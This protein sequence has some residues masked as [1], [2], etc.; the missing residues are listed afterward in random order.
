VRDKNDYD[1]QLANIMSGLADSVLELSDDALL[2][3]LREEGGDLRKVADHTR[4]VLRR[5]SKAYR[6]RKLEEAQHTYEKQVAEIRMKSYNLPVSPNRQRVLLAAV[7]AARPDMQ[8]A[9][10]TAQ[11]RD[12]KDLSDTDV[13]GFLK[14]LKEL[15]VL[16][17]LGLPKQES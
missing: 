14:Q 1:D 10:L 11:H 2:A 9:L 6:K 8:S 7:F 15:G 3:E 5:A 12:F 13:E 4:N 17:T 16:D